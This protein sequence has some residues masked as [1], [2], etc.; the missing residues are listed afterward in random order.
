MK[1]YYSI[2]LLAFLFSCNNNVKSPILMTYDDSV[3]VEN[4]FT[5]SDSNL[6]HPSFDTS[7]IHG[8][9]LFKIGDSEDSIINILKNQ[10]G[11][12]YSSFDKEVPLILYTN[13]ELVNHKWVYPNKKYLIKINYLK[14]GKVEDEINKTYCSADISTYFLPHFKIDKI[15]ILNL[16]LVFYEN[17]LV[18]ISCDFSHDLVEAIELKYGK[19]IQDYNDTSG[20]YNKTWVNGIVKT[21]ATSVDSRQYDIDFKIGIKNIDHSL[22]LKD[23]VCFNQKEKEDSAELKKN[24]KDL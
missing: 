9:G 16:Y 11:Y 8:I 19:P 6:L 1:K 12:A 7:K 14:K 20:Y 10:M 2:F 13:A 22:Y 15:E 5:P 24:S 21:E 23:S 17:K 18:K 4:S 3:N